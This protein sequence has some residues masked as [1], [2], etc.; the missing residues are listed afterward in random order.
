MHDY[1][2]DNDP[3]GPRRSRFWRLIN[4][5][6]FGSQPWH[7]P[8]TTLGDREPIVLA[9]HISGER[10]GI[11]LGYE[12]RQHDADLYVPVYAA[13]AGDVMFCGETRCGFSISLRHTGT[14]WATYY[15]HLS[16][17]FL[18]TASRRA[19]CVRAGD[20][21]GY[22]AKSPIHI[23]FEL[24]KW[25]GASGFVAVTPKPE[26]QTWT[27]PLVHGPSPSTS[28]KAA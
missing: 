1:T 17:V 5:R 21:I 9:D 16:K 24:V 22:A 7:W 14:E 4:E 23:R 10:R 3:T 13:Q 19:E 26:M 25:T 15:G 11:D 12:P 18:A 6:R 8:L 2:Y 28:K 27:M 20:V